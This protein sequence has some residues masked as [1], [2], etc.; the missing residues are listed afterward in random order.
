MVDNLLNASL[1]QFT[2]VCKF[3]GRIRGFFSFMGGDLLVGSATSQELDIL[4][5]MRRFP[6][7]LEGF[8]LVEYKGVNFH[9]FGS[10][11]WHYPVPHFPV[12]RLGKSREMRTESY[13]EKSH[14]IHTYIAGEYSGG[15]PYAICISCACE[16]SSK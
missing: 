7:K 8:H 11:L 5:K 14:C 9:D 16:E 4:G 1:Y 6:G 2:V 10:K 13:S 15:P 12:L 3:F